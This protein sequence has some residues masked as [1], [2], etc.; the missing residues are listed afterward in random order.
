MDDRLC[1]KCGCHPT[2]GILQ[3]APEPGAPAGK[4]GPDLPSRSTSSAQRDRRS[5]SKRRNRHLMIKL[6]AVCSLALALILFSALRMIWRAQTPEGR[7][8]A[9]PRTAAEAAPAVTGEDIELL[10]QAGQK[11]AEV[12]AG[13]LAAGTPE[14]RNQFVLKP[15]AT[16]SRMA[17]FYDLNPLTSIDPKTLR[18]V[19]SSV[20]NLP[21][22]KAIE[23]LWNSQDG[24]KF[25][26]VFREE[27][28]E[29][30]LDWDHFA[31][32]SDYPWSLFLAGNGA[33]SGE[34]R[35]LARERLAEDR[36]NAESI[37]VVLYAPR[38]AHPEEAGFQSPEFLVSRSDRNGQLLDAAFKM[39]RSGKQVF[40]SKLPD[41]NPDEM[42]R[43]RVKV[44]RSEVEMER[45]F[46]IT[47][48]TAC[49]WYSVY[50]PGVA[51]VVPG[52][53]AA[54]ETKPMGN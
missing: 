24:K 41:L 16:A 21:D 48:V 36:K 39:A 5:A 23:T 26:A 18:L 31:R 10:Q 37:S 49:H 11:C 22:G 40:G 54:P 44:R 3:S 7:P 2:T 32:H 13:F 25:D 1:P 12:F 4:T 53:A 33:P 28:G 38:F 46:E 19:S 30:R 17:R 47:E 52:S 27:N 34:F 9:T 35:L 43:V 15:V 14:E 51:P 29:W 20:L 42:I 8:A 45:K 50:D 6:M